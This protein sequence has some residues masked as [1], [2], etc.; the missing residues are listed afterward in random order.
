VIF[1]QLPGGAGLGFAFGTGLSSAVGHGSKLVTTGSFMA[2]G[3]SSGTAGRVGW[4]V[5]TGGC[6]L[7]RG[8]LVLSSIF[9]VDEFLSGSSKFK[10]FLGA[11]VSSKKAYCK[12][13]STMRGMVGLD[14]NTTE[15]MTRETYSHRLSHRKKRCE[16]V[17]ILEV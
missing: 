2:K 12:R 16:V 11:V 8:D 17:N 13:F 10:S 6:S 9:T 7:C 1:K 4:R 3:S 5:S 15:D 14:P